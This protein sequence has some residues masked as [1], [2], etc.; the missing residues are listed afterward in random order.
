MHRSDPTDILLDLIAQ[1]AVVGHASRKQDGVDLPLHGA[2]HHRRPLSDGIHHGPIHQRGFA[3]AVR[4][5]ALHLAQIVRSAPGEQAARARR[6][7]LGLIR[8]DALFH[9]GQNVIDADIPRPVR[10]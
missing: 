1:L 8:R 6:V 10:R 3:V 9:A 5:H 7:S 2:G 4:D